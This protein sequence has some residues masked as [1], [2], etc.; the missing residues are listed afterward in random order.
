LELSDGTVRA[1][2]CP[3]GRKDK[4][5]FD[6]ALPGFGLRVTASG[7]RIF[8]FQYRVGDKVRRVML[9]NFGTDL[10]TVQ[11][12]R[13]AGVLRGQALDR[14]DPAAER[15]AARAATMAAEAQAK[16]AAAAASYSIETLIADWTSLR[17]SELSAGYRKRVPRELRVALRKW[18]HAPADAFT[19]TDSVRVL[20]SA[21]AERGPVAANRLRSQ[22]GSCWSWALRRGAVAANPWVATP[23]PLARET[24]RER[25]LTDAEVGAVYNAAGAL[26]EPLGVLVRLLILTGQRRGEVAG[27]RWSELDLDAGLWSMP[28]E[29]T[30]NGR[31]HTTPLTAEAMGLIRSV[32]RRV[33]S[34]LVFENARRTPFTTF[35]PL[36]QA[37]DAEIAK[38]AGGRPIA[39][40]VLHDLRRSIATGLQRLGVRLEVT[41]AILNH[42]S[43]SRG[44]IIGVYQRHQWQP[45]KA[46]AMRAWTAHV[47]AV[48]AGKPAAANVTRLPRRRA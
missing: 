34:D 47:L 37:L 39:P 12:R 4:L 25:V 5:I 44:G 2:E 23:R 40:Y 18:L 30:K 43:G 13:K 1:A 42:V 16:A 29:R 46:A 20:D 24:P 9:G 8:I 26:T 31:A 11:A 17:L 32:K 14:R 10:T 6:D 19:R 38:A 7:K 27:M 48:A 21:K 33:E 22:C 28:G 41:E 15:R 3:P 35:R 36:K 45:E